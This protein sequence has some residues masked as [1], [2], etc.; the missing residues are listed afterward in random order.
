MVVR[1]INMP[2]TGRGRQPGNY[3]VRGQ[4]VEPRSASASGLDRLDATE[5]PRRIAVMYFDAA[6]SDDEAEL[7]GAGLTPLSFETAVCSDKFNI[8]P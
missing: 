1:T 4:L 7:L 3:V 6:G 8:R 5:D 2:R